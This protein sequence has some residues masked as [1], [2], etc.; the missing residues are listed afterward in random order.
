MQRRANAAQSAGSLETF[1]GIALSSLSPV[2]GYEQLMPQLFAT[3]TGEGNW[4]CLGVQLCFQGGERY[5]LSTGTL[6]QGGNAKH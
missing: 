6:I 1:N 4:R 5:C 2:L 3:D